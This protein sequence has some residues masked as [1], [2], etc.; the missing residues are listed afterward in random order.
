MFRLYD[1]YNVEYGTFETVELCYD[2]IKDELVKANFK[3]YYYRQN[4]ID[5]KIIWVD[6]GSHTHFFFIEKIGEINE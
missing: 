5:N 1:N 2:K 3:S 6:Y 4:L